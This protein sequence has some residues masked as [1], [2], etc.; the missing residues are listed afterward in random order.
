MQVEV[1]NQQSL[2]REKTD[3]QSALTKLTISQVSKS[4]DHFPNVELCGRVLYIQIFEY[5]NNHF[6]SFGQIRHERNLLFYPLVPKRRK[7]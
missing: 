3:N 5:L 1:L 6:S 2:G 4:F 7:R